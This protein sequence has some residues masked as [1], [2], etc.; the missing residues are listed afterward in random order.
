MNAETSFPAHPPLYPLPSREGT[1]T[2]PH[3]SPYLR[4]GW[5]GGTFPLPLWERARESGIFR[6]M[7]KKQK[8]T[9]VMHIFFKSVKIFS[10]A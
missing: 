8:K 1:I 2:P 6:T 10:N 5:V 7:T 4:G 3:S 9:K